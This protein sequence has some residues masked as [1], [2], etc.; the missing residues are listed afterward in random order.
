MSWFKKVLAFITPLS[1]VEISVRDRKNKYV[2]NEAKTK[3][4]KK[5]PKARKKK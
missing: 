4:I 3:V 5:K 1:Y 2:K